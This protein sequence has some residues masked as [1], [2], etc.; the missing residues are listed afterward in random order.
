MFSEFACPERSHSL[1]LEYFWECRK[2]KTEE[3]T[4]CIYSWTMILSYIEIKIILSVLPFSGN[5]L[6]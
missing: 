3:M 6:V 5:L 4:I 1:N 2:V